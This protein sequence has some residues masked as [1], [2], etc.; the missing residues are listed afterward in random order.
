M[1]RRRPSAGAS[2]P[3]SLT[4]R[5]YDQIYSWKDYAAESRRIRQ[6]VRR[7]GPA[8]ASSLLDV[9]CGSG[10]HL[11]YLSRYFEATGVDLN[12]GMLR[13]ARRKLPRVRF[14]RGR[15]EDFRLSARFDVVTC[16]FSAIGYVHGERDLRRTLANFARHLNPGGVVIVEPW[17]SRKVYRAGHVH[18]GTYGDPRYPIV[19]MNVARRRGDRSIM[20]MHHLVATPRGVRHWVEHHDLGMFDVP[21]YFSAFRAAGLSPRYLR[22]GLMKERGVYVARLPTRRSRAP[23]SRGRRKA[24]VTRGSSSSRRRP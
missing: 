6:W 17:L 24:R 16:L 5:V 19:R 9:A 14:V 21:T 23:A 3:Y 1:T 12:E 2:A 22:N 18:L 7:F 15:M 20:D 13:V 10:S 11:A 8:R 4:S